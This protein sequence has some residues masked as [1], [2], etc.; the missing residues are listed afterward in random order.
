MPG[1][2]EQ[3]DFDD[4]P[5]LPPVL[6]SE[7]L[8]EEEVDGDGAEDGSEDDIEGAPP[9]ETSSKGTPKKKGRKPKAETTARQVNSRSLDFD[10][11]VAAVEKRHGSLEQPGTVIT[12][13]RNAPKYLP[14]GQLVGGV[15]DQWTSRKPKLPELI[16]QW[17]GGELE[18]KIQ[19]NKMGSPPIN[20][21]KQVSVGHAPKVRAPAIPADQGGGLG[22][23]PPAA[24]GGSMHPAVEKRAM[25]IVA[26]E[27][28]HLRE[29]ARSPGGSGGTS[30]DLL[31]QMESIYAATGD[32]VSRAVSE[33]A[34]AR[35]EAAKRQV[36]M[37]EQ[38][39]NE[40]AKAAEAARAE[41]D[42]MQR[43]TAE[44][45]QRATAESQGMLGTLLP[46][47]SENASRQVDS[48]T[49]TFLQ[50]EARIE[51]QHAKEVDALYR[52]H[53]AEV[54]QREMQ[55]GAEMTRLETV[56]TGQL[57]ML[58]TQVQQLQMQLEVERRDNTALRN[59]MAQ[60]RN[61]QVANL[62]KQSDPIEKL[63]QLG[64]LRDVVGE[65]LPGLG[66]GD[67]GDG[68]SEDA[69]DW[70]KMINSVA[71]Y[72]GPA[73]GQ[74]LEA[75]QQQGAGAQQQ[76]LA[77]M[78]YQQMLAA[79][80][81]AAGYPGGQAMVPAQRP[82]ARAGTPNAQA[83]GQVAFDRADLAAAVDMLNSIMDSGTPAA[84]AASAATKHLPHDMLR[85]LARR[86]PEKVLDQLEQAGV[87]HGSLLTAEGRTYGV[88]F[89][90]ALREVV[91]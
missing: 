2:T 23:P 41:V 1:T 89:L 74:V 79:Q 55:H 78:Q 63:Q 44:K 22:A 60:L 35:E 19:I 34:L 10:D 29:Q 27:V 31:R 87:L 28:K 24:A 38:R 82:P 33:R 47:F 32:Q 39:Y 84:D 36:E 50:R 68:L 80:Q 18:V 91:A 88:A 6:T 46:V 76:Q 48:M 62:L 67:G 52:Q 83:A 61:E 58:Q 81:Q 7:E 45:I 40:A 4:V 66:G 69:P 11:W 86:T 85:E 20:L 37:A 5:E 70:M 8:G 21:R 16:E 90:K 3:Q 42:K 64:S 17:G 14:G 12:L 43:E 73:I 53:E 13:V 51:A 71:G 54:R 30:P 77:A 75:R 59:D 65:M 72:V 49:Q 9:P 56:Y 25:D 26:D 15:L 57:Q